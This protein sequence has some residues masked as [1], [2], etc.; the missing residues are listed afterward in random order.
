ME[1][2]GRALRQPSRG[3]R[4]K[5]STMTTLTRRDPL[6]L[7]M[8]EWMSRWLDDRWPALPDVL[9]GAVR[10]EEFDEDGVHVVR[11]ELPDIDPEK[12][13][14]I[15]LHDGLL[16]ISGERTE[17]SEKKDDAS[18]RSEFRYGRFERVLRMPAGTNPDDVEATYEDG[19]LEVR[20]PMHPEA[21]TATKVPV[22]RSTG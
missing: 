9:G 2:P 1:V 7:E 4:A 19:V 10:V 6:H 5:V 22:R 12:D 15:S 11:A 20:V 16:H 18:Y 14:D 21:A 8:P 3:G 17:R 13:V